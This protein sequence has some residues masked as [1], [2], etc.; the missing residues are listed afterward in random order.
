MEERPAKEG[1]LAVLPTVGHGRGE[2]FDIEEVVTAQCAFH[3]FHHT[4]AIMQ[5]VEQQCDIRLDCQTSYVRFINFHHSAFQP[6]CVLYIIKS[7]TELPP[8]PR[9]RTEKVAKIGMFF[10]HHQTAVC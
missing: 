7:P 10:C 9:T 8:L 1:V 6:P 4:P 5:Y 3:L 2:E